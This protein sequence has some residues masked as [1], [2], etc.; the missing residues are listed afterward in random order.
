M[1][2][3]DR[4]IKRLY[5]DALYFHLIRSGLNKEQAKIEMKKYLSSFNLKYK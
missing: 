3:V 5:I 1:I 2:N 4:E